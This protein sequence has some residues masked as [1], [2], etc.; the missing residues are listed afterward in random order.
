MLV[1]GIVGVFYKGGATGP[2]G[3]VMTDMCDQLFRRGPDS[4]GVA[5]YGPRLDDG[6]VVRVD[7]DRLD[8]DVAEGSVLAAADE[9]ATL[10]IISLASFKWSW[11]VG[12]VSEAKLFSE[13]IFPP[14][15][16]F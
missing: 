5:L 7:L 10:F 9:P 11:R 14:L 6:F 2:V 3:Q 1:C 12:N 15:A 13:S 8:L 16:S 4:A